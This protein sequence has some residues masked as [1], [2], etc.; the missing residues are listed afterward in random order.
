MRVVLHRSTD[1][2]LLDMTKIKALRVHGEGGGLCPIPYVRASSHV[3]R[4]RPANKPREPPD[5]YLP[6]GHKN[7]MVHG[8]RWSMQAV[9][10]IPCAIR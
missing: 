2:E 9:L 5:T 6:H 7:V 1:M 8:L 4:R 3:L 10:Y